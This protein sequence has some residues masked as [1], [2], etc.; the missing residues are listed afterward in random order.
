MKKYNIIYADPPWKFRNEKTGGSHKSGAGQKYPVMDLKKIK[1][2]P[3]PE[4]CR[5]DAVLFLWV[6]VAIA[7]WGL[8]VMD[9][10]KFKYKTKLF[11]IK[12]DRL[13]LGFWFRNQVEELLFG[14]RGRVPAFRTRIKNYVAAPVLKHSEKPPVFR[15]IIKEATEKIKP[16]YKLEMFARTRSIGWDVYG[17]QVKGSIKL[18]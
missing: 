7:G 5:P 14:I 17:D 1:A 18:P 8:E 3:V 4:I 13:G 16:R 10:W 11:W 9:A 15:F 6:P 2:L 12:T